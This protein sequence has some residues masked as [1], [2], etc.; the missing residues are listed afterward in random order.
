MSTTGAA[1]V[2]DPARSSDVLVARPGHVRTSR[3]DCMTDGQLVLACRAGDQAAWSE[4]VRRHSQRLWQIARREGLDAAAAQ[5]AVQVAWSSLCTS[6]E[7]LENVDAVSGW[8]AT[9]VRREAIRL[10]K[11]QRREAPSAA[12]D[13]D[14][15]SSV[16]ERLLK[17]ERLSALRDAF[18][19]LRPSD[20]RLLA[21]LFA[22]PEP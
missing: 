22:D 21:M 9:A 16:D 7:R 6:L 17:D 11:R 20:Q 19:R 12:A 14:W 1:R 3:R 4:L 5:D 18:A 2:H 10:S 15:S 8:L 13:I